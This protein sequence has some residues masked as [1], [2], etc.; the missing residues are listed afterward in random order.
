[1]ILEPLSSDAEQFR[2][3]LKVSSVINVR[4]VT[5]IAKS[6]GIHPASPHFAEFG[7]NCQ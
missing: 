3:T 6:L 5:A 1:L 2:S 4:K 7:S